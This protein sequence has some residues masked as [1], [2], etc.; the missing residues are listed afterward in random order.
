MWL[1]PQRTLH[2]AAGVTR[3]FSCTKRSG[4]SGALGIAHAAPLTWV[5]V[6]ELERTTTG[7]LRG[8]LDARAPVALTRLLHKLW[9]GVQVIQNALDE[10]DG[11][12]G[13][14]TCEATYVTPS[15]GRRWLPNECAQ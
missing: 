2:L 3:L 10:D 7:E 5:H 11:G 14:A 8:T 4:Q 1:G 13:D 6:A 15:S 12:I 9:P